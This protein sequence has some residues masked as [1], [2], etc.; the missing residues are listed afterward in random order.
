MFAIFKDSICSHVSPKFKLISDFEEF[1][2][3]VLAKTKDKK[4]NY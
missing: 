3:P 1:K 4:Y 2:E